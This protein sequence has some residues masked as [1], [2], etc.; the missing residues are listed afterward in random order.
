MFGRLAIVLGHL[1]AEFLP[2]TQLGDDLIVARPSSRIL[3]F[4]SASPPKSV[5]ES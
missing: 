3:T 2:P 4:S 5:S 1:A